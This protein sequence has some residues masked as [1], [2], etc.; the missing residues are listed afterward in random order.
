MSDVVSWISKVKHNHPFQFMEIDMDDCFT[1]LDKTSLIDSVIQVVK[2][3]Y[4]NCK[5][6]TLFEQTGQKP[7][8]FVGKIPGGLVFS[9]LDI[10]NIIKFE[11]Y[12]NCIFSRK[13][14]PDTLYEQNQGIV[15]GSWLSS[16]LQCLYCAHLEYCHYSSL[17]KQFELK[18]QKKFKIYKYT[19]YKD[20][21]YFTT[22]QICDPNLMTAFCAKLY[23]MPC[24][25]EG[26]GVTFRPLNCKVGV[27]KFG[28]WWQTTSIMLANTPIQ[29]NFDKLCFELHPK[30]SVSAVFAPQRH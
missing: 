27:N 26:K 30:Y 19:R 16:P 2:L 12:S 23:K 11:L 6:L 20:N 14:D 13:S 29:L 15:M 21:I 25:L 8:L 5:H 4:G 7:S 10:V 18:H 22:T 3:I 24:K 17:K 9:L 1:N 28:N